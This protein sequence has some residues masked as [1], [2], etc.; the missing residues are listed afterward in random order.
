MNAPVARELLASPQAP[1]LRE[2]PYNYTSWSDREIVCRLLGHIWGVRANPDRQAAR[3]DDPTRRHLLIEPLNHRRAETDHRRDDDHG[4]RDAQV[5]KLLA[6][7]RT[8]VADFEARFV[9]TAELRH[10]A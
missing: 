7:A 2:I 5:Q 3:L 4:P 1:R 8:A 10:A 9:E 6:A